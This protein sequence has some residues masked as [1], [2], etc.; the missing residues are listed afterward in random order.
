[1]LTRH[2]K[3]LLFGVCVAALGAAAASLPDASGALQA[4][5][6]AHAA[7]AVYRNASHLYLR[8][9]ACAWI[10]VEWTAAVLL[11]RAYRLLRAARER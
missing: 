9:A 1:M 7:D 3:G 8:L 10:A 6:D 2:M 4:L 11:W 5:K